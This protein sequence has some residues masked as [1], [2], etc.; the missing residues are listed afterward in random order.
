M[1]GTL[2]DSFRGGTRSEYLAHYLLS[3]LGVV[4]Q[5][6]RQEDIGADFHC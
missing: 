3:T 1:V 5:V 4:V 2:L 6:P